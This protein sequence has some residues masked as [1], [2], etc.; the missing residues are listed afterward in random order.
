MPRYEHLTNLHVEKPCP[1]QWEDM[2]GED[3]SRFCEHC[4]KSVHN[5]SALTKAEADRVLK[6]ADRVCV[7]FSR[8]K[9]GKPLFRLTGLAAVW[10][11][12]VALAGC[13]AGYQQTTGDVTVPKPTQNDDSGATVGKVAVP[14]EKGRTIQSQASP[15]KPVQDVTIGS[16]PVRPSGK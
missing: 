5:L 1:K 4:Q 16:P 9:K 6:S 10:A 3:W 13:Q 8:D 11:G 14:L 15:E 2:S 7:R 12:V